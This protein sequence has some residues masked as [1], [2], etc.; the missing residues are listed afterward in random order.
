MIPHPTDHY[1]ISVLLEKNPTTMIQKKVLSRA[2][3]TWFIPSKTTSTRKTEANEHR[4]SQINMG[5]CNKN[6]IPLE[7]KV[8]V[9]ENITSY[10]KVMNI[11][12]NIW[13]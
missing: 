12:G 11:I 5:K 9:H 1:V 13:S 4:L 8:T 2:N 3:V 10:E 6:L 7:A